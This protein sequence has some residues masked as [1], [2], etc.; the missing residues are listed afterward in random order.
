MTQPSW[1]A[2]CVTAPN[3]DRRHMAAMTA[4]IIAA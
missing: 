4:P 3:D 2:D 1:H